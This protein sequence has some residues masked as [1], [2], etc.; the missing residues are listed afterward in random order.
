MNDL[1]IIRNYMRNIVTPIW[2]RVKTIGMMR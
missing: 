1:Q 2:R